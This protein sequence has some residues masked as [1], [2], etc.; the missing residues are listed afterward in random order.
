MVRKVA[1]GTAQL[2][3]QLDEHLLAAVREFARSRGETL[4]EVLELAL[5]RHL[6]NPPA[7]QELPPLPPFPPPKPA[8]KKGKAK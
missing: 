4:R 1:K 8:G 5:R 3:A 6:A 2:A 7:I